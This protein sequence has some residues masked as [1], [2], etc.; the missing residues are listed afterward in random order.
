[1]PTETAAANALV[2]R[3]TE[4]A[5]DDEKERWF[6]LEPPRKDDVQH[7]QDV[8]FL[9]LREGKWATIR[10]YGLLSPRDAAQQS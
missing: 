5:Y 2:L 3:A 10:E 4:A 6:D 9:T 7:F 8:L 1:M